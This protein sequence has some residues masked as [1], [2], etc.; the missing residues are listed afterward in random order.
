MPQ[1]SDKAKEHLE[2][3]QYR[4]IGNH[5]A[6]KVCGWTKNMIMGKGGCYKLKFYGIMSNQCMQMTTSISCAN[7]CCFCWR[8][9]KAP[10]S[11]EWEWEIDDPNIIIEGSLVEHRKLLNGYGGNE[12]ASK[13]AYENSKTVRHVALSL[14]GEPIAYPKINEAIKRFHDRRISTFLV[15]NAQYP[16][17]IESLDLVTQLYISLDAPTR[18][19]LKE[20]DNPLFSDYWE[21]MLSSLDAMA[22]KRF[23]KTIRLTAIKGMN[24][25]EAEK[26][27]GLIR[28][29]DPDFIE[30]KAYMFIGASRQRL[31]LKNMPYHDEVR[32][33]AESLLPYLKD[34][35]I[36]SEHKPSRVVLLA[37]KKYGKQTWID[38]DKFFVL[39]ESGVK[40]QE[41]DA[42]SYRK[43]MDGSIAVDETTEEMQLQ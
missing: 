31:S 12:K 29:A 17:Q 1:L 5:S 20:I 34:Y 33:F 16:E 24:M 11:R 23:R 7:R 4:V 6:V 28:R 15:T 42:E 43:T 35:E 32:G 38:Y 21:R 37:R 8:G 39:L 13:T 41:I 22:K 9:Y 36:A 14:T 2:K 40:P 25:S 30:V 18:E 26:Y 10:V 19:M 3:Q 27:A